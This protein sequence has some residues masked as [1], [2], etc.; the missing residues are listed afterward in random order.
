MMEQRWD[1]IEYESS[2]D[3]FSSPIS[4]FFSPFAFLCRKK[5]FKRFEFLIDFKAQFIRALRATLSC[6]C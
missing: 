2:S 3:T 6:F 4:D 5:N 1:L